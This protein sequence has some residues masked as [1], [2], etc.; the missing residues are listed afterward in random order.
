MLIPFSL[1]PQSE[2][3]LR[4]RRKLYKIFAAVKVI[5]SRAGLFKLRSVEWDLIC[6][7]H[8]LVDPAVL[9]CLDLSPVTV[10]CPSKCQQVPDRIYIFKFFL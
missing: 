5:R 8:Q 7:F 3:R 4:Q 10:K 9:V 6:L 1:H 2:F